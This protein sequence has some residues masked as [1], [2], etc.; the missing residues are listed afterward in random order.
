MVC[1]S[2]SI[3]GGKE[4]NK[5]KSLLIDYC[6]FRISFAFQREDASIKFIRIQLVEKFYEYVI[7]VFTNSIK[8][9]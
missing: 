9:L 1:K 6:T 7:N 5:E 2:V 8:K 4:I 3:K